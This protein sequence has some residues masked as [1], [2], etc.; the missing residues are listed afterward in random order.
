MPTYNYGPQVEICN[1]DEITKL[2]ANTSV[3]NISWLVSNELLEFLMGLCI[4]HSF[5]ES[6]S[7]PL[8]WL[9]AREWCHSSLSRDT[10]E[11]GT[12][13]CGQ[14]NYDFTIK[15][16]SRNSLWGYFSLIIT[17]FWFEEINVYSLQTYFN[18]K[19]LI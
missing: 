15:F 4:W 5:S 18:Q 10:V 13:A 17:Y 9:L 3:A 19:Q 2:L 7:S 8:T 6:R 12:T 16:V 1:L 14:L 11:R